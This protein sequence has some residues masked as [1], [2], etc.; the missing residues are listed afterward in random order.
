MEAITKEDLAR[1]CHRSKQAISIMITVKKAKL[2]PIGYLEVEYQRS[3]EVDKRTVWIDV[4]EKPKWDPHP[5]LLHAFASLR[6]HLVRLCEQIKDEPESEEAL[7]GLLSDFKVTGF[8]IGGSDEH[9]GVTLIGRK[10]LAHHRVLN[11]VSPFT[12][13]QD[14]HNG[15]AYHYELADAVQD[16]QREVVEYLGGK[17]APEPQTELAFPEA[18]EDTPI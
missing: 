17:K 9:E 4:V 13:W 6:L 18:E 3:T 2:T 16:C 5:D 7:N 14:E 1:I 15:Y 10:A 8:V 12:K 11:L